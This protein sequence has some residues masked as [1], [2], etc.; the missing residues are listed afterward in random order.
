MTGATCEA[1]PESG[2]VTLYV[3][4]GTT[5]LSS[6][7]LIAETDKGPLQVQFSK[8]FGEQTLVMLQLN[9]GATFFLLKVKLDANRDQKRNVLEGVLKER[10]LVLHPDGHAEQQVRKCSCA[11]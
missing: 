1:I 2:P 4:K 3:K 8:E 11:S 6:G 9:S 5:Y 10:K 7:L